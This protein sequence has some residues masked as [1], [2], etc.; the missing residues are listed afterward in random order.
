MFYTP[1][2]RALRTDQNIIFKVFYTH[3]IEA[4]FEKHNYLSFLNYFDGQKKY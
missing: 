3:L 2:E 4:S 1:L